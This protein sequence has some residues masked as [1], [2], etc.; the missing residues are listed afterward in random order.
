M[1]SRSVR[2][3][4]M[5][6]SQQSIVAGYFGGSAST[7][8]LARSACSRCR[9]PDVHRPHTSAGP[10]RPGG[11][12]QKT[13]RCSH[14]VERSTN[15]VFGVC[16]VLNESIPRLSK[17]PLS[18]MKAHRSHRGVIMRLKISRQKS[19]E[20]DNALERTSSHI[21]IYHLNRR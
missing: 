4:N 5:R 9:L 18:V 20:S 1:A 6:V 8:I 2:T 17:H 11:S 15:E 19:G 16:E 12:A 13:S 3:S 14:S 7:R 10:H 21:G